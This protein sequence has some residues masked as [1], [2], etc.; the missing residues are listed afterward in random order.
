MTERDRGDGFTATEREIQDKDV[1]E[2]R[3]QTDRQTDRVRQ[4][5]YYRQKRRLKERDGKI[6][7]LTGIK[8]R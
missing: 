1:R 2:R 6:D 3:R 8:Y 5:Q 7:G 4:T